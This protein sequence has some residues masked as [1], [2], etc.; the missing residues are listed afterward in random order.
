[1]EVGPYANTTNR[2][3]EIRNT[4]MRSAVMVKILSYHSSSFGMDGRSNA[5]NST[6][7][8]ALRR[9]RVAKAEKDDTQLPM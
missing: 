8:L 5:Q 1:M 4:D 7:L 6:D 9:S 2:T 3:N